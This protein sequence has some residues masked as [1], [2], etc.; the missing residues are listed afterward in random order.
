[1]SNSYKG[2]LAHVGHDVKIVEYRQPNDP[3]YIEEDPDNVALECIDCGEVILDF[4]RDG[5][6]RVLIDSEEIVSV[7][8]AMWKA[9]G[10]DSEA[11]N[12]MRELLERIG[13]EVDF[14]GVRLKEE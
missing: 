14:E 11:L 1:M 6:T 2:L 8:V 13:Y 7:Y 10:D 5:E 4:D 9:L 12:E 3:L